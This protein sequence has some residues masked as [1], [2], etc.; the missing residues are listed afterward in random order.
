[1]KQ[2][3]I[4]LFYLQGMGGGAVLKLRDLFNDSSIF[5]AWAQDKGL[6]DQVYKTIQEIN[7]NLGV[8]VQ[9]GWKGY[10]DNNYNEAP[11]V[12]IG[13]LSY[14][15]EIITRLVACS[16]ATDTMT[17]LFVSKVPAGFGSYSHISIGMAKK[18]LVDGL[19][20][21]LN[22]YTVLASNAI[23]TLPVWLRIRIGTDSY[24]SS[25]FYFA[26]S[27]DGLNW[28]DMYEFKG[29][30]EGLNFTQT[31][32]GV[33]LYAVNGMNMSDGGTKNEVSGAFDFFEMRPRSIN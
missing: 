19:A 16:V 8:G 20:V 23:K 6:Q 31:P 24:Q 10:W 7:G 26:Y 29:R 21:C 28:V 1:M 13:V 18:N 14:P 17:G 4:P 3:G 5:W 33:G 32:A 2:V 15:C 30:E 11:K 22:S 25:H 27:L 9:S 12:Y